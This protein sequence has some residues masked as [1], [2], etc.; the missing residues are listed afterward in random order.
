MTVRPDFY[1]NQIFLLL[2][3]LIS[4]FMSCTRASEENPV[5]PPPTNPLSSP[6][7]GYG[8]INVS[9]THVVD[10][11]SANAVSLGYLRQGSIV[12]IMER[13]S[14]TDTLGIAE[15]WVFVDGNYRG[16]LQETVVNVYDNEAK[17]KTAGES[18]TK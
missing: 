4:A 9:Y 14:I 13:R 17:A 16:W 18:M 11:P 10:Q 5:I 2:L 3:T 12:R 6:V 8:V 15:S 7:V 1:G